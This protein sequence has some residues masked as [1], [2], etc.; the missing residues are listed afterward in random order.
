[1]KGDEITHEIYQKLD[2]DFIIPFDREDIHAIATSLDDVADCINSAATRIEIYKVARFSPAMEHLTDI[3]G[4]QVKEIDIAVRYIG[5]MRN[6]SRIKEALVRINS[7]ENEADDIHE[8]AIG[9]LFERES[10][11]IRILKAKEI[12]DDLET[13]TDKCEDVA[14][15]IETIVIKLS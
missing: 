9:S 11:A 2:T 8:E 13:A 1:M 12:L 10:D 6:I 15:V 3:I 5:S 14:N 4:R 7:L